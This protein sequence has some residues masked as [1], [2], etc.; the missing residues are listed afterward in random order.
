MRGATSLERP[1]IEG[2]GDVDMDDCDILSG[3]PTPTSSTEASNENLEVIFNNERTESRSPEPVDCPLTDLDSSNTQK[4]TQYFASQQRAQSPAPDLS[5]SQQDIRQ[6]GENHHNMD[7]VPCLEVHEEMLQ[8]IINDHENDQNGYTAPENSELPEFMQS[9][10]HT[11]YIPEPSK[12]QGEDVDPDCAPVGVNFVLFGRPVVWDW[13]EYEFVYNSLPREVVTERDLCAFE[14]RI[15]KRVSRGRAIK[16]GGRYPNREKYPDSPEEYPKPSNTAPAQSE[17]KSGDEEQNME[18]GKRPRDKAGPK[19]VEERM[20]KME[21]EH[22]EK[23]KDMEKRMKAMEEKQSKQIDK[24]FR[25]QRGHNHTLA[26]VRHK[27]LS[28]DHMVRGFQREDQGILDRQEELNVISQRAERR[29]IDAEKRVDLVIDDWNAV[30]GPM[31]TYDERCTKV[32]ESQKELATSHEEYKM[33]WAAHYTSIQKE[34]NVHREETEKQL[35]QFFAAITKFEATTSIMKENIASEIQIFKGLTES[36]GD[37]MIS[38]KRELKELKENG[39]VAI[40]PQIV[41]MSTLR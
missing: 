40:A 38:L 3:S 36:L 39:R 18:R 37:Q 1:L 10:E 19:T 22:A 8:D 5:P 34:H 30:R 20:R 25:H 32:E 14:R 28:L 41:Q 27:H 12:V 13:E 24:L 21:E 4:I 16:L 33:K 23:L 9:Q 6:N 29:S 31:Y 7:S 26:D 2:N 11:D 35:S 17:T 15:G